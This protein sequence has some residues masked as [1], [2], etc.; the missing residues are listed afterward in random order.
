MR[1]G[2]GSARKKKGGLVD[3]NT[4]EMFPYSDVYK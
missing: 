4:C 3:V 1:L 2:L